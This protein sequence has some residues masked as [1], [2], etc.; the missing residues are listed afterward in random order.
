MHWEMTTY[1]PVIGCDW[2]L[3]ARVARA[4]DPHDFRSSG[5]SRRWSYFERAP[6]WVAASM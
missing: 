6:H 5:R 3:A 1:N 2:S 4:V